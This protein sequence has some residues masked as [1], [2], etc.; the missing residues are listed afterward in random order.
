[1]ESRDNSFRTV[2]QSEVWQNV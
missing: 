2:R 1:M